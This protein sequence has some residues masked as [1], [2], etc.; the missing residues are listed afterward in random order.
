[1]ADEAINNVTKWLHDCGLSEFQSLFVDEGYDDLDVVATITD[2]ELEEIGILKRGHRKKILLKIEELKLSMRQKAI[3]NKLDAVKTK[4]PLVQSVLPGSSK[5]PTRDPLP[6][7]KSKY[8]YENPQ[9]PRT[10]YFNEILPEMFE[11]AKPHMSDCAF[12]EYLFKERRKRWEA[13]TETEK[14]EQKLNY[15]LSNDNNACFGKYL[16]SLPCISPADVSN[17]ERGVKELSCLE[18]ALLARKSETENSYGE[19][20]IASGRHSHAWAKE[21]EKY[22]ESQIGHLKG[23]IDTITNAKSKLI[24]IGV[25]YKSLS[26]VSLK[27]KSSLAKRRRKENAC[28][29]KKRKRKREDTAMHKLIVKLTDEFTYTLCFPDGYNVA[30]QSQHAVCEDE[31]NTE[32]LGLLKSCDIMKLDL[33]FN[34][35]FFALDALAIIGQTIAA[36]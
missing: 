21:Q 22:Y 34:Q 8:W 5:Q 10:K 2:Q 16:G 33:L 3:N 20:F 7:Q 32:A 23:L 6:Y 31:I 13:K 12:E 27:K 30:L 29:A 14:I 35:G 4:T 11:A 18:K 28:K 17:C 25:T 15:I 36:L 1:M 19:L 24:S 9:H 26:S